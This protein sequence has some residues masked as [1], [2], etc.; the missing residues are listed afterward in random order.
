M[1]KNELHIIQNQLAFVDC[2]QLKK[3]GKLLGRD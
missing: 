2:Y 3:L 1:K